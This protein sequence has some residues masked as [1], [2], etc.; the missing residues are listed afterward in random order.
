MTKKPNMSRRSGRRGVTLIEAVLYISIALALIVGGL[1]FYRQA[2][3]ASNMNSMNR[4]LSAILVE[5]RVIARETPIPPVGQFIGTSVF[6]NML[7]TRESVPTAHVDMTKDPGQRIRTPFGGSASF[8]MFVQPPADGGS[9][10]YVILPD[11]PVE[12]CARLSANSTAGQTSFG[13]N[14][15]SGQSYDDAVPPPAGSVQTISRGQTISTSSANC[16]ASDL[17]G[18]GRVNVDFT[19]NYVE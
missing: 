13:T 12:A 9:L 18:D 4:L 1:V 8:N 7:I 14:L 5:V 2:S 3:F 15:Q 6:E 19:F 11:L 17:D 16:K 10:I